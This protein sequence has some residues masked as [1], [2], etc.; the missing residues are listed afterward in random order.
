MAALRSAQIQPAH[1]ATPTGGPFG[2]NKLIYNDEFLAIEI[3]QVGTQLDPN[4]N[5]GQTRPVNL[6]TAPLTA[7]N[8]RESGIVL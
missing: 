8:Y 1:P 6:Q 4:L 3:G 5:T 2:T 7:T